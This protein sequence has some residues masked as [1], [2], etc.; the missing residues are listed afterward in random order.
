H[1]IRVAVSRVTGNRGT[2]LTP[3]NALGDVRHRRGGGGQDRVI[4]AVL[5]SDQTSSSDRQ[6]LRMA[7]WFRSGRTP[8]QPGPVAR[9]APSTVATQD[10]T[11]ALRKCAVLTPSATAAHGQFGHLGKAAPLR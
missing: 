10:A 5:V 6:P 7:L 4:V 3:L 9:S 2:A 11:H 8:S 1:P